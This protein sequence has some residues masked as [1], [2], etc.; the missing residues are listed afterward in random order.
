[1]Q[2]DGSSQ[3]R[4]KF[5]YS[6]HMSKLM[7][8]CYIFF[9]TTLVQVAL[10]GP[11]VTDRCCSILLFSVQCSLAPR[12]VSALLW[13]P[14]GWLVVRGPPR[15]LGRAF[16][17]SPRGF[18]LAARTANKVEDPEAKPRRTARRDMVAEV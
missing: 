4:M 15:Q 14:G 2:A 7:I 8:I 16:A 3:T 6:V 18:C 12:E 9:L 5:S 10:S 17:Q 1:M 13:S 11:S